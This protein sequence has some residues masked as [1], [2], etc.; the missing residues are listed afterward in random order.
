[1]FQ[2]SWQLITTSN[3]LN[4]LLRFVSLLQSSAG[5]LQVG[6]I[7]TSSASAT[8]WRAGTY[9]QREVMPT[10]QPTNQPSPEKE[11]I[12]PIPFMCWS[13]CTGFH[14]RGRQPT[15]TQSSPDNDSP[16]SNVLR[17]PACHRYP[18]QWLRVTL[19]FQ[20]RQTNVDKLTLRSP[21]ISPWIRAALN[22]PDDFLLSNQDGHAY[23]RETSPDIFI[24][25]VTQLLSAVAVLTP[26]LLRLPEKVD[27]ALREVSR[28]P[29]KVSLA[30]RQVYSS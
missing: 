25:Y 14:E 7:A 23:F 24:K 15:T 1:M 30:S 20:Q 26:A 28:H 27:L 19:C 3:A 21:F 12:H 13:E 2:V 29:R 11:Q 8:G 9:F 17:S 10:N 6:S 16:R 4:T 22:S 5:S 18:R